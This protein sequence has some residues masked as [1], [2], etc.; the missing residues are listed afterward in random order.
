MRQVNL[1]RRASARQRF[2]LGA[3][4]IPYL[5]RAAATGSAE[6]SKEA[7]EIM[8]AM[9]IGEDKATIRETLSVVSS[10][11]DQLLQDK[12]PLPDTMP[13]FIERDFVGRVCDLTYSVLCQLEDPEHDR[14]FFRS[15]DDDARDT[16]IRRYRS[17]FHGVS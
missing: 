6:T 14:S 3:D 17:R 5:L 9:L 15:M 8:W 11:L 7:I 2:R 16:E 1:A 10:E 4:A 13:E 12:R